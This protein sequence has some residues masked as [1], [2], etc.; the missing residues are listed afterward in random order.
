[1]NEDEA[2]R[3]FSAAR[4]AV[5][6]TADAAGTPHAVPVTFAV[7][8][9]DV[10]T[11]VDGKRKT[12]TSLKRHANVLEN[13]QVSLLVQR[14]DDDWS[15]LWWVRADGIATLAEDPERIAPIVDLLRGKYSQYAVVPISGPVM[16]V[17]VHTW[18]GWTAVPSDQPVY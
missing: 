8:G 17:A 15:A 16:R 9:D 7:D 1:M 18:R 4:V 11:A 13:P 12:T 2:R 10:C 14:W 5:L 6:A 3:R